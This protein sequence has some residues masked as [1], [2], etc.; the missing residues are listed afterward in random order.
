[1]ELLF[2]SATGDVFFDGMKKI[3]IFKK[4]VDKSNQTFQVNEKA[5]KSEWKIKKPANSSSTNTK[6][7]E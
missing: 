6:M 3:K 1:M 5:V 2:I 7:L 4:Y